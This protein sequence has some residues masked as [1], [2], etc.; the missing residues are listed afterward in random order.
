MP[1]TLKLGGRYRLGRGAKLWTVVSL[2]ARVA[3]IMS[4][5]VQRSLSADDWSRLTPADAEI[6]SHD[7]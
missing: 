6:R 4:D 7:V 3:W 1:E 5:N 2:G